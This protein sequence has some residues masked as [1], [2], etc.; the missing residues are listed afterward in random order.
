MIAHLLVAMLALQSAPATDPAPA[1][2]LTD[3]AA[4]FSLDTLPL[5]Q[6]ADGY[7]NFKEQQDTWTKVV[8]K[9]GMET[10]AA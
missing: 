8:L 1:P 3:T 5:E 6:A 9:P 2:M 7:K 4:P 10:A